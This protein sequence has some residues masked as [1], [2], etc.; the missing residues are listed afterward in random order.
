MCP[1]KMPEKSDTSLDTSRHHGS[2][3]QAYRE[4]SIRA[5]IERLEHSEG[6]YSSKYGNAAE[7][8]G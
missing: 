1:R 2:N 7:M 8:S 3:R 6:M 4:A 5:R